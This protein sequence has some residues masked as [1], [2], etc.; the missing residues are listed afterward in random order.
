M[1]SARTFFARS[2]AASREGVLLLKNLIIA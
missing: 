1:A 2:M